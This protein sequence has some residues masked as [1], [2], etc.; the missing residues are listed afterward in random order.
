[1]RMRYL[2]LV[3]AAAIAA[4][5]TQFGTATKSETVSVA[6]VNVMDLQMQADKNLPTMV[7]ADP[8]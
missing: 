5:A 1:M 6:T 8:I 3:S 4:I 2:A 7:T